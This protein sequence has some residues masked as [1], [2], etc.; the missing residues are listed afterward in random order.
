ME[1]NQSEIESGDIRMYSF[2][3][4]LYFSY[5]LQNGSYKHGQLAIVKYWSLLAL[6]FLTVKRGIM[7]QLLFLHVTRSTPRNL[8]VL[9]RKFQSLFYIKIYFSHF[10][11]IWQLKLV[12]SAY[13]T[14]P[15]S[16]VRG[17][18]KWQKEPP[19]RGWKLHIWDLRLAIRIRYVNSLRFLLMRGM[20]A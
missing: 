1:S 11:F 18:T 10:F 8:E 20:P 17:T 3:S 16:C 6:H 19:R 7:N 9:L 14:N 12:L 13:S 4:T 5:P 2:A 15:S